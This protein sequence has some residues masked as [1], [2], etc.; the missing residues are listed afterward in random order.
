MRPGRRA[1]V[2]EQRV[3]IHGIEPIRPMAKLASDGHRPLLPQNVPNLLRPKRPKNAVR[4]RDCRQT[5]KRGRCRSGCSGRFS[6]TF[7]CC[8]CFFFM[9]SRIGIPRVG[10]L[11]FE[12]SG[13]FSSRPPGSFSQDTTPHMAL[14]HCATRMLAVPSATRQSPVGSAAMAGRAPAPRT[15]PDESMTVRMSVRGHC[16][17]AQSCACV[18]G[19]NKGKTPH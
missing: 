11:L 13:L 10:L 12:T 15:I 1:S 14:L 18:D 3:D 5:R 7:C 17:M 9:S 6:F 16:N 8:R 19:A 4:S 2:R